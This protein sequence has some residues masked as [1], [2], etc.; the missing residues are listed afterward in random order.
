MSIDKT[1]RLNLNSI[2]G[3]AITSATH[4][5]RSVDIRQNSRNAC[6]RNI[7]LYS[8]EDIKSAASHAGI[9]HEGCLKLIAY[10]PV[11]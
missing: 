11:K 7:P 1:D 6:P 10:L 8:L 4:C 3:T 2:L 5:G 9:S